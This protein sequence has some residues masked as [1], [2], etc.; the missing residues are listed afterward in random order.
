MEGARYDLNQGDVFEGV[1]VVD[2]TE[3]DSPEQKRMTAVVVSHDCE[4]DKESSK[5]VLVALVRPLSALPE[6]THSQIREGKVMNVWYLGSVPGIG[7]SCADFRGVYRV[8]RA[9]LLHLVRQGKRLQ[10]CSSEED[11]LAL[12]A[13]MYRFVAR[14]RPGQA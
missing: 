13:F 9:A 8:T 10:L 7:E 2:L 4:I 1:L 5:H 3:D 12:A 11:K 14:R 6:G